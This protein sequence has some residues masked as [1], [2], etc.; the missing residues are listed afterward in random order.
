[1][2]IVGCQVCGGIKVLAGSSDVDGVARVRWFV[3]MRGGAGAS[4]EG[5]HGRERQRF[6]AHR[7][8]FFP[9]EEGVL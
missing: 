3:K 8:R 4:A 6:A 7:R 9:S 1:M 2:L 5:K